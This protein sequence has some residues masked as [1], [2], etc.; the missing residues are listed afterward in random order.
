MNVVEEIDNRVSGTKERLPVSQAIAFWRSVCG[1]WPRIRRVTRRRPKQLRLCE[2]LP[3]GERRF[4]AVVEFERSRFLI[5]GTQESL[6]MLAPLK[7]GRTQATDEEEEDSACA[8]QP[9]SKV[10]PA[11]EVQR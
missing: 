8:M 4:V 11:L 1:W 7:D 5:G 9:V 3:L 6:V 2:S 10:T